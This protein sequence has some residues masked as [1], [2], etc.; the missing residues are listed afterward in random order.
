M[1]V[2]ALPMATSSVDD[3]LDVDLDVFWAQV[4]DNVSKETG[5]NLGARPLSVDQVV[6]KINPPKHVEDSTKALAKEAIMKT[7]ICFQRFGEFAATTAGV[8]F[9]YVQS[10]HMPWQPLM[11]LSGPVSNA[12]MQSTSSL[13]QPK[14]TA[15]SSTTSRR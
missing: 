3:D 10:L 14:T 6:A 7:L 8:V 1:V 5:W 11:I 15:M 13:W 4:I 9:G 2:Q 12:S